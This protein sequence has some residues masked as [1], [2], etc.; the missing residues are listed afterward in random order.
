MRV[1]M[2]ARRAVAVALT[3]AVALGSSTAATGTAS[4]AASS[5]STSSARARPAASGFDPSTGDIVLFG[6]VQGIYQ[7]GDTW[8]GP[9]VADDTA[10]TVVAA[11][12]P[13]R[14][15]DP[16]VVQF[17]EPVSVPCCDAITVTALGG[18]AL[19][20]TTTCASA[21]LPDGRCATWAINHA[22]AVVAGQYYDLDLGG[23]T[24]TITDW[25]GNPLAPTTSRLRASTTVQEDD[26]PMIESWGT[27]KNPSALGGDYVTERS[28]GATYR[29]VFSGTTVQWFTVT[30]PDQGVAEVQITNKGGRKVS[31]LV[32]NSAPTTTVDAPVTFAGLTDTKHTM[33]ISVAAQSAVSAPW[34]SIDGFGLDG[35]VV[36]PSP[37]AKTTFASSSNGL[38]G[39][40][41]YTGTKGATFATR[42]RGTVVTWVALTGPDGG[43][44]K[45]TIDGQSNGTVDLYTAAYAWR[46]F[47]FPASDAVHTFEI[48]ALGTKSAASTDTLVGL[49][50]IQIG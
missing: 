47:S 21:P 20:I 33:T 25:V 16:F 37:K 22:A 31:T 27:V 24:A 38:G 34:V 29:Y 5:A 26:T 50:Q 8:V 18:S 15:T 7:Y 12:P 6:G 4:A 9:L 14:F 30:G 45:V 43:K 44:A 32:D 36:V 41:A 13:A 2:C 28:A 19:P 42:F 10:P 40:Y 39:R 17:S 23:G 48:T 35:S 11:A 49:D 1:G 46:T 3:C